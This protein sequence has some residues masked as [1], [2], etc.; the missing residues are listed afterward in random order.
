MIYK[1]ISKE[2][3]KFPLQFR[4]VTTELF[5]WSW[6]MLQCF[7]K[8]AEEAETSQYGRSLELPDILQ[9]VKQARRFAID[10]GM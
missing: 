1:L 3:G 2:S 10:I 9:N 7:N 6:I 8:M 4:L 5:L